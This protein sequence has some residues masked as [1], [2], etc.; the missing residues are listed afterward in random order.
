MPK[1]KSIDHMWR[2][3]NRQKYS[4]Y[5]NDPGRPS[6]I[7]QNKSLIHEKKLSD[8]TVEECISR[9]IC[10]RCYNK[11]IFESGCMRCVCGWSAC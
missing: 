11:L 2:N 6:E 7:S 10:P 8:L 9:G 1:C 4:P 5:K 3:P